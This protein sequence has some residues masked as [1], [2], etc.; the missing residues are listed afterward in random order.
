MAELE[1][2]SRHVQ[3]RPLD[4]VASAAADPPASGAG[5]PPTAKRGR[6]DDAADSSAVVDEEEDALFSR[7]GEESPGAELVSAAAPARDTGGLLHGLPAGAAWAGSTL[8]LQECR[9]CSDGRGVISP[10]DSCEP[11]CRTGL[12]RVSEREEILAANRH[13]GFVEMCLGAPVGAGQRRR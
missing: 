1:W 4:P 9:V 2:D 11:G 7:E 13:A 5:L 6:I 3:P 12:R 8:P 10:D